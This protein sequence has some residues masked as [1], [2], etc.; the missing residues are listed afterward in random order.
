LAVTSAVAAALDADPETLCDPG[1]RRPRT[2]SRSNTSVISSTLEDPCDAD[3]V[4]ET[5]A[6]E[7]AMSPCTAGWSKMAGLIAQPDVISEALRANDEFV[8]LASDGLWD[9]L[10]PAEAVKAVRSELRSY[11]D[12]SMAAERLVHLALQRRADDNITVA[13]VKL[14]TPRPEEDVARSFRRRSGMKLE[15]STGSIGRSPD[16]FLQLKRIDERFV[17]VVGGF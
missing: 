3:I 11:D 9:V 6:A 16:S 5:G 7:A 14:F 12:A 1:A 8:I 17:R 13:I 2:E 4:E 10:S 15:S